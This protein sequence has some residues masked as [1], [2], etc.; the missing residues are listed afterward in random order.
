MPLGSTANKQGRVAAVNIC[1]GRDSF[2]GVL[3]STVCKVFDFC[4]ARTGLGESA[5]REQGHNVVTV[6]A[7]APDKAHFMPEA[8]LLMLKLIVSRDTR[9]L[10]GAQAAGPG[11]GDKRVDV[12][13][14][15][16]YCRYD[17]GPTGQR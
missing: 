4:V 3:G 15:G 7:P 1:G 12:V 6:L 10:L 13:G 2:F 17:G 5:A 16:S 11:A 14:Y 9:R 8:K